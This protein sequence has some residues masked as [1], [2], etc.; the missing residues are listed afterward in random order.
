MCQ[1]PT[2]IIIWM[3]TYQSP[4]IAFLFVSLR[5]PPQSL[6]LLLQFRQNISWA[7][8]LAS[9][10]NCETSALAF[11]STVFN[12]DSPGFF[13]F[14]EL[15]VFAG[16]H[17]LT[18]SSAKIQWGVES[19]L[20]LFYSYTWFRVWL[21]REL[22]NENI[23]LF[24]LWSYNSTIFCLLSDAIAIPSHHYNSLFFM[25]SLFYL[26]FHSVNRH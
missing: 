12:L 10:W 1:M 8:Y 25:Y 5:S 22:Q 20:C 3:F 13:Y 18:V 6:I 26:P 19:L 15:V 7:C 9:F 4:I 11:G 17:P 24:R 2:N 14:L 16:I 21:R 23:F